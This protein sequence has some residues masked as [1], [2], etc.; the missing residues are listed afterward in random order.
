MNKTAFLYAGQGSQATGM[1]Q[2]LYEKYPEFRKGFD[3][4][5]LSFDLHQICFENPDNLL[6]QTEY[7]QPCLVAFACGMTEVL[8]A[9]GYHADYTCGLSLG[10]YSALYEAGLWDA[11][12][13]PAHNSLY[14]WIR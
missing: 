2:D 11:K 9:R 6:L 12:T 7:T 1:G 13:A 14:Q 5:E 8:H 4:G 10:E 3:A